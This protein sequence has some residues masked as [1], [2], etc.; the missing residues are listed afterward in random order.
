[1]KGII[2]AHL[3]DRFKYLDR[4]RPTA[5]TMPW[6]KLPV[7][8]LGGLWQVGFGSKSDYLLLVS[9][10][11]RGVV[12]C[13]TGEIVARDDAEYYVEPGSLE[14]EGIGPLQDQLVQMAGISGGGLSRATSDGWSIELHPLSWPDE[15][16]IL[17]PPGQTMLWQSPSAG[18]DLIKLQP[19]PSPLVAFGFSPTGKTLVIAT[20]SDL[21]IF[22]RG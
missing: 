12:A 17:C 13:A 8:H 3:E 11:G 9:V 20:S 2:P 10:S 21:T 22:Y 19:L 7:V 5:P 1:M 15:E 14:G 18:D 16:L 4:L 6:C